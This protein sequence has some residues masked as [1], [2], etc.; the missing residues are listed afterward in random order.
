M[1]VGDPATAH[2]LAWL[3]TRGPGHLAYYRFWREGGRLRKPAGVAGASVFSHVGETAPAEVGVKH[4]AVNVRDPAAAVRH[5]LEDARGVPA[6][7]SGLVQREREP[8]DRRHPSEVRVLG[9]LIEKEMT[10]PDYYPLSLNALT[11]A[12]NQTSNRDPVVH[13]EAQEVETTLL[14]LKAK[15]LRFIG[16]GVCQL[17]GFAEPV[18]AWAVAGAAG[19]VEIEL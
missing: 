13:W 14:A 9:S 16:A 18:C 12:C 5:L 3:A 1:P 19:D 8:V 2:R 4:D 15:G 7:G 6:D 10:T 11:N 17:K